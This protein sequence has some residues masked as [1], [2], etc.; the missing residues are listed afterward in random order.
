[1]LVNT[2]AFS[3]CAEEVG[4]WG[5]RLW[6]ILMLSCDKQPDNKAASL[7]ITDEGTSQELELMVIPVWWSHWPFWL[8]WMCARTHTLTP[9]CPFTP[10]CISVYDC[11]IGGLQTHS[12]ATSTYSFKPEPGSHM[13]GKRMC[14]FVFSTCSLR[15]N[16]AKLTSRL[17]SQSDSSLFYKARSHLEFKWMALN[18]LLMFGA[19]RLMGSLTWTNAVGP[20][21]KYSLGQSLV[22]AKGEKKLCRFRLSH[23]PWGG[24]CE[25]CKRR[26]EI[27]KE[28]AERCRGVACPLG[29]YSFHLHSDVA[30]KAGTTVHKNSPFKKR[31]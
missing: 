21:D 30:S 23:E 2:S 6:A 25:W 22:R 19:H 27:I 28:S 1:M 18:K 7:W 13:V 16:T 24:S 4:G 31:E 10:L 26:V 11:F 15:V 29:G 3:V 5:S 9:I 14:W 12:V 20:A 17:L 8:L